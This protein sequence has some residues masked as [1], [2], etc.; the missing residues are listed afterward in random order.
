MT[1]LWVIIY[2]VVGFG[3]YWINAQKG[4]FIRSAIEK[5]F[6]DRANDVYTEYWKRTQYIP[7]THSVAIRIAI[8]MVA[9]LSVCFLWP[10]YA[11]GGGIYEWL[12]YKRIDKIWS[13][14]LG[15]E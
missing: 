9:L 1:I 7:K 2:L 10:L 13:T 11:I 5:K 4:L 14:K 3:A 15:I 12:V 6:G 8:I